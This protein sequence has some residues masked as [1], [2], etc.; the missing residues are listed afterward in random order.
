MNTPSPITSISA[1]DELSR[2]ALAKAQSVERGTD[3]ALW[4]VNML[5]AG[6]GQ[7]PV[8]A[9]PNARHLRVVRGGAE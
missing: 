1:F 3:D 8:T 4:I 9:L 5:R 6:N 7:E 2:R